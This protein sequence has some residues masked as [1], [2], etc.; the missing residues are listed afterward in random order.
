M[1]LM[2]MFDLPVD[3][4][5]ARNRYTK[6]RKTLL[7]NGF[8]M[9]QFSVYARFCDSAEVAA[10]QRRLVRGALPPDGEVRIIC[11]TDRQFAKMEVYMGQNRHRPEN[12]P[13]QLLLF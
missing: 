6:F 2:A 4:A 1:W 10:T 8:M 11:I 13:E 3:S 12:P 7:S 5:D 9:M